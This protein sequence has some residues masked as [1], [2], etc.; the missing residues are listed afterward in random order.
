MENVRS[1]GVYVEWKLCFGVETF[2]GADD[3]V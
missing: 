1:L 3:V 2:E